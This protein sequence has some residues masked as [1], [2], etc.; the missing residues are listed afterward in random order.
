METNRFK[1]SVVDA[2]DNLS[3][4]QID[5]VLG[6]IK[7]I[8]R[9]GAPETNYSQFRTNAMRQIKDALAKGQKENTELQLV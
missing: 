4:D 5:Q 8:K 6:Y 2:L 3:I 9:P 7:S 1:E